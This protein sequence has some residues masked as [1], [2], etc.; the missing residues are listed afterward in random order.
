[1]TTAATAEGV[2]LCFKFSRF[3]SSRFCASICD[4]ALIRAWRSATSAFR[5]VFSWARLG[6]WAT[7]EKKF[8]TGRVTLVTAYWS[9]AMKVRAVRPI[10]ASGPESPSR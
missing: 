4:V 6:R 1:M 3:C 2:K 7:P 5:L 8:P 9:G 10:A